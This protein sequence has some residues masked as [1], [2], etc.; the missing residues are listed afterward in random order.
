MKRLSNE[1]MSDLEGGALW[2]SCT[3]ALLSYAGA[4]TGAVL[5]GGAGAIF[6]VLASLGLA[7]CIDQA[8]EMY[9]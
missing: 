2:Y 6:I 9:A 4:I 1:E 8:I 3:I 5:S 7:D